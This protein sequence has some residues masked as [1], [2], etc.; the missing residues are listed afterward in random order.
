MPKQTRNLGTDGTP[1]MLP[2]PR[3]THQFPFAGVS[4]T[5]LVLVVGAVVLALSG[6]LLNTFAAP[7]G[8]QY[9]PGET[10]A[11]SCAPGATNCTVIPP[12][13]SGSNSD[14]T[15][16]TGLTTALSVAQGGTGVTSVTANSLLG[17]QV[18]N[19]IS[20]IT[21]STK[22]QMTGSV[23]D[24]NEANF[25]FST[26][27]GGSFDTAVDTAI[28]DKDN[29]NGGYPIIAGGKISA[30]ILPA[31]PTG[32]YTTVADQ[33][34]R[35]ALSATAGDVAYQ[36]DT[37]SVWLYIGPASTDW[38]QLNIVP[39][40]VTSINGTLTGNVNLTPAEITGIFGAA[41]GGTGQSSY[42]TGDILVA[43]GAT[44]LSKLAVGTN[45]QVLKVVGG[46]VQWDTDA[47]GGGGNTVTEGLTLTGANIDLG[48]PITAD[49]ALTIAGNNKISINKATGGTGTIFEVQDQT[50]D[51]TPFSI[52]DTGNVG[53]GV[54]APNTALD[55]LGAI[56]VRGLATAPSVSPTGEGRIYFDNVLNKYRVSENG[57]AYA[58]LVGGGGASTLD[59]LTDVI[60]TTPATGEILRYNG[61]NWVNTTLAGS[62][63]AASGANSDITSLT[64]LSTALSIAQ[65]GTGQVTAQAAIDAL[66]P[67]QT[68][69]NGKVLGTDGTN[70]SWVSLP[71]GSI[72]TLSDITLTSLATNDFLQYN[73][74]AWVNKTP[75]QVKT[76][77]G[78]AA[79]G[80]NSDITS[81]T[82]LTTALPA[83]QGGTGFLTI[84]NHSVLATNATDVLSTISTSTSGDVLTY[85]GTN[86]VWAAPA[87]GGITALTGEV[88][89]GPG[90]GSQAAT[91]AADAVTTVKIL[92][93]AV[94]FAK[95]QNIATSTILGRATAGSGDIEELTNTQVKTILAIAA[96]D[97]SGLATSATTDTTNATNIT[98]GTLAVGQGGTGAGSFTAKGVIYGNGTSALQVTAAGTSGQLLVADASGVPTFVTLSSDGTLSNTGAFTLA[99]TAV[100]PG[101]YTLANITVD[102]KGRI[103][104]ASNGAALSSALLSGKI[105]VGDGTNVAVAQT[106][107]GD[108]TL[109]N[110]G[111]IQIASDS[112]VDADINAAAAIALT[113]L[114]TIADATILGNNSGGAGV[115]LALTAAQT[116]TL[117]AISQADVSGLTTTSSPSFQGL[118]LTVTPLGETSGGTGLNS[119][120]AN[121]ILGTDTLNDVKA[122]AFTSK[123]QITG[124]TNLDVNENNF[125]FDTSFG[126]AFSSDVFTSLSAKDDVSG[127]YAKI[128]GSGKVNAAVLPP[129]TYAQTF[130]LPNPSTPLDTDNDITNATYTSAAAVGDAAFVTKTGNLYILAATPAT[131]F[132]NWIL[133]TPPT[134]I[135][136]VNG[137]STA[138]FTL[139]LNNTDFAGDTLG[140][141]NGGT[142]QNVYTV[143]DLLY[144]S[145]T[146]ALSNLNIGASGTFLKSSGTA[147]QWSSIAAGDV[148][149]LENLNTSGGL[150]VAKG[151][152][153]STTAAGAIN[154]LLPTQTGNNLKFLQSVGGVPTWTSVAGGSIAA[155]TDVQLTSLADLDFLEYDSGSSKWVNKTPA[156]V[157]TTLGAASSG[158]NSDITSLTGLTTDLDVP[159]GGTGASTLTGVVIGSGASAL[160]G[161]TA[162]SGGQLLR[163]NLADTAFEF[164]SATYLDGSLPDDTAVAFSVAE[165]AN[166]YIA[167]NTSNAGAI[168]AFG[169]ATTN[170]T[171]TFNGT[172]DISSGGNLTAAGT[173]T[174]GGNGGTQGSVKLFGATSGN[175]IVNTNAV[176]GTYTL[177]LPATAGTA[178]Q[179]LTTDGAGLL[180]WSSVQT[181]DA[182]LAAIAGLTSAADKLPYFT[183]SG[184]AALA[185][186][187]TF[188]RSLVDDADATASLATIGAAKNDLTNL[189]GTSSIGIDLLSNTDNT[190]SLG[191]SSNRWKDLFLGPAS[192]HVLNQA[193]AANYDEIK[194]AYE[195]NVATLRSTKAGTGT[196]RAL[197]ILTGTGATPAL[198]ADTS[199]NVGIGT[200][201]PG[202][203]LDVQ[204]AAQFGSGNVNL[205]D[206]TGKIAAINATNFASL[207]GSALTGLSMTSLTGVLTV[208]KGGT[209]IDTSAATGVPS[210]SSGTWTTNAQLPVT[211]GGTG[212]ATGSITGTGVLALAS[213]AASNLTLTAGTSG[214]VFLTTGTASANAIQFTGGGTT[215]MTFDN[216]NGQMALGNGNLGTGGYV[217]LAK[218]SVAGNGQ[219][220]QVWNADTSANSSANIDFTGSGTATFRI[221][222]AT[223]ASGTQPWNS[224][225]RNVLFY[226]PNAAAQKISFGAGAFAPATD[227]PDLTIAD[228]AVGI[229]KVSPSTKLDVVGIS[230]VP[231]ANF[232]QSAAPPTG[233]AFFQDNA[234]AYI[235]G[236][237]QD[238]VGI[239]T[240]TPTDGYILDLQGTSTDSGLRVKSTA[241]ASPATVLVQGSSATSA[242][243]QVTNY[244]T[245]G[246]NVFNQSTANTAL[247]ASNGTDLT[248][249]I[250]GAMN[251]TAV[252]LYI[253]NDGDANPAITIDT[254]QHVGIGTTTPGSELEIASADSTLA[255]IK[256]NLSTGVAGG[257]EIGAGDGTPLNNGLIFFVNSVQKGMLS[258]AGNWNFGS[259]SGAPSNTVTISGNASVGGSY[260]A[261]SAPTN[262]LIV[263][264]NV[265]IGTTTPG[266]KL[267]ITL[268]GTVTNTYIA[269]NMIG[270]SSTDGTTKKT[271]FNVRNPSSSAPYGVIDMYNNGTQAILL[272]ASS[273]DESYINAGRFG[274]GTTNPNDAYKLDVQGG[275]INASGS[276][277]SANIILTSDIRLKTNIK[278]YTINNDVLAQLDQMKAVYYDWNKSVERVKDLPSDRQ[279][280][281]IAQDVQKVI[282]EIVTAGGDGYLGLDYSKLTAFLIEVNKAQQKEI[283]GIQG[284]ITE[285]KKLVQNSQDIKDMKAKIQTLDE[286][287][288]RLATLDGRIQKLEDIV[289]KNSQDIKDIK[290]KREDDARRIDQLEKELKNIKAKKD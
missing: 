85:N 236:I 6:A 53:I 57:A 106:V 173:L 100:T 174:L 263:E 178:N 62:G 15:A 217:F 107:T 55:L 204:G 267:D 136:S 22:L 167:I 220:I 203:L 248:K 33:T 223:S 171:F 103:T 216:T 198:Y 172:G 34:A 176:A 108:V 127:G 45:G 159:Q 282:P 76:A 137:H 226:T 208:A 187:T 147:P 123:F 218:D 205:I 16:I 270:A 152:T 274:I 273:G 222:H 151:G 242:T 244:V 89:A 227:T 138:S 46:V 264:G 240:G 219:N 14:I 98:S 110:A 146:T 88:T 177:T 166:K 81:I 288:L 259:S 69:N 199:N 247:W 61:T 230:G 87:S 12:A 181:A 289:K 4:R 58:D 120:P 130:V 161:L 281:L 91:I 196:S 238:R 194:L 265:G 150:T 189:T 101:S 156:Q 11:P 285:V 94:T 32:S 253:S 126:G 280:G 234:D 122:L 27:P 82:G 128:N 86:I 65:G 13:L 154:N 19:V 74:T 261:T 51:T 3:P 36:S 25:V 271:V 139:H 221:L 287:A 246:S 190:R 116:K 158:A 266:Q 92:N 185:D 43:S 164:Y 114:A 272:S 70:S 18:A 214:K 165:A 162:S 68:G 168:V 1:P 277:R 64:G 224:G 141:V 256:F 90:T 231:A 131:S 260:T 241:A 157:K 201:A 73:G 251:T 207:D 95:T 135:T 129:L 50:A 183:G 255:G 54:S 10:L 93:D 169:N 170:P 104:A 52:D 193:D 229:N 41:Q 60:I 109:S 250:I 112:I 105:Y 29:A 278:D 269:G 111:D 63:I 209:G 23:L 17:A 2:P 237:L 153:G 140:V 121:T 252:P 79:S 40:G 133:T 245:A 97:V 180:S 78:A 8:S 188:G 192:L 77:I 155:L 213:A 149:N 35:E 31:T 186:F 283:K 38:Q 134:G 144:A 179:V 279:F 125:S 75:A 30:S 9:L 182:E 257:Y 175:I 132:A 142:G 202:A 228:G 119:V 113:K 83:T 239:G 235:M 7:P 211:L 80:A 284:D 210:V 71:G 232:K 249:M 262:G 243:S 66:L 102:A 212:T 47:T 20:P 5:S 163:R 39:A 206:A 96:G 191:S 184:T 24:V 258:S 21:L 145:G 42:T 84:P 233:V 225:Q 99:S 197:Q 290:K 44:T 215:Y 28:A 200:T 143:G 72:A 59:G 276:V 254:S 56:S 49:V 268:P 195:T 275:D 148:P 118:T 67:A 26:A 37:S 48:G 160:T 117:L 286:K 124:G 115:P